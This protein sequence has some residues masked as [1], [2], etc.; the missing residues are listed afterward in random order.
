MEIQ[1]MPFVFSM[2]ETNVQKIRL[3]SVCDISVM[4]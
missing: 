3:V 4:P 2:T 1:S